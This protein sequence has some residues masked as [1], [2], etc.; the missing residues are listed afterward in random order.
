MIKRI[1]AENFLCFRDITLDLAGPKGKP[2]WYA[3]IYGENGSGKT[4]LLHTLWFLKASLD[5]RMVDWANELSI[6]RGIYETTEHHATLFTEYSMIGS[7]DPIRLEYTFEIDGR[8]AT[9][10]MEISLKGMVKEE[11]VYVINGRK[12]TLFSI[13][14]NDMDM[15]R[16]FPGE[17]RKDMRM[18]VQKY[19]GPYSM[20]SILVKESNNLSHIF[21]R[22]NISPELTKVVQ[23][24]KNLSIYFP[25]RRSI[26]FNPLMNARGG[27]M[28]ESFEPAMD[29]MAEAM[30]DFFCGL[31]SD[32]ES[33]HYVKT[34]TQGGIDFELVF[35]KRIEGK[36]VTVPL[37]KESSG[38]RKLVDEFYHIMVCVHGGVEVV[39]EM[40]SGIHD[41]L[42]K[43]LFGCIRESMK[44]QLIATTHN[45]MLLQNSDP[46][47][48]YILDIDGE[49]CRTIRS[50]YSIARTQRCNNNT[51]RYLEGDLGGV[52]VVGYMD[53]EGIATRFF[54]KLEGSFGL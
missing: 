22:D 3:L 9:Y 7:K 40:D 19:W 32:I 2:L 23:Y 46:R 45:T 27:Q 51:K 41:V 36:T 12:A 48:T 52:P 17:F 50:V 49:G 18:N 29:A 28:P 38:T 47:G 53:L 5:I 4:N 16:C 1:H 39:D 20:L 6:G 43:D 13:T 44:G 8:D 35:D 26:S 37:Y 15:D 21:A 42:M 54:E 10:L 30:N 24:V 31:Y 34:R 33:V 25:D 14:E 11:L